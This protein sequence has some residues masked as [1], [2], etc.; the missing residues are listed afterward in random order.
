[1]NIQKLMFYTGLVFTMIGALLMSYGI[2][3]LFTIS[4]YIPLTF[5]I[6]VVFLLW[7]FL[8]PVQKRTEEVK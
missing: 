6:V 2:S 3:I 7:Y 5:F 8:K 4:F 1:M